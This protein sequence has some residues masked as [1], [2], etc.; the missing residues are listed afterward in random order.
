MIRAVKMK[1]FLPDATRSGYFSSASGL[2]V[3]ASLQEVYDDGSDDFESRGSASDEDVDFESEEIAFAELLGSWQPE[4]P[5]LTHKKYARHSVSRCVHLLVDEAGATCA[6]GRK[7]TT[8][9]IILLEK[10]LFMHPAC[11]G[12]FRV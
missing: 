7:A 1:Q 12:C 9:Y 10:P 4:E 5:S 11:V 2:P 6:C 8:R 3:G